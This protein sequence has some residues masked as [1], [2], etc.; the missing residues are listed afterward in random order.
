PIPSRRR[1]SSVLRTL[2]SVCTSL[3]ASFSRSTYGV[4]GETGGGGGEDAAAVVGF[5]AGLG[6]RALAA[7][8]SL[9]SAATSAASLTTAG[10]LSV[11]CERAVSRSF[12]FCASS[13]S[14][15]VGSATPSAGSPATGPA[16]GAYAGNDSTSASWLESA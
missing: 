10:Y 9:S 15:R 6:A 4:T 12:F 1:P 11:N 8:N 13:C 16:N 14:S 7:A 3:S 2:S 5:A